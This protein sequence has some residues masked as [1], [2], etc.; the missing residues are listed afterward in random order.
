[1]ASWRHST[2]MRRLTAPNS[3]RAAV[4]MLIRGKTVHQYPGRGSVWI[5]DGAKIH[6]HPD[7]V[8]YLRSLGIISIFLPCYCPFYNPIDKHSSGSTWRVRSKIKPY[9]LQMCSSGSKIST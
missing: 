6:C 9:S 4:N 3:L 1:M 5:L 8:Y 2:R 7:I